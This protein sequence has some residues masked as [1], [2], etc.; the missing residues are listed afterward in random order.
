MM[1]MMKK[2]Q[3]F[4]NQ[5]PNIRQR[6]IIQ[7]VGIYVLISCLWIVFSDNIISLIFN[8]S[9]SL[10]LANIINAIIFILITGLFLFFLISKNQKEIVQVQ[11]IKAEKENILGQLIENIDEVFWAIDST[12]K[13]IYLSPSYKK[14]FG[15]FPDD[16]LTINELL[17]EHIYPDDKA[18]LIEAIQSEYSKNGENIYRI[19][20]ANGN[21]RWIKSKFLPIAHADN[22]E[23][24]ICCIARDIT[25]QILANQYLENQ[26]QERTNELERKQVIADSLSEILASL[27]SNS[28]L[29][30]ILS[31]IMCK[32]RQLLHAEA[33]AVYQLN[34]ERNF[35]EITAS[36]GLTAEYISAARIPWGKHVTGLAAASR[37]PMMISNIPSL[38]NNPSPE[39]NQTLS[40]LLILLST[41]YQSMLS[42]PLI[43]ENTSVKGTLNL[44]FKKPKTFLDGEISLANSFGTYAILA[45][46]NARLKSEAEHAVIIA[47]RNRIARDLHDSVTQTLFSAN[48]IANVLPIVWNNN[49]EEGAEALNQLNLLTKGALAEMRTL[50]LELRPQAIKDIDINT[51]LTQLASSVSIKS[52]IPI[53]VSLEGGNL[54]LAE[55]VKISI[56]RICQEALNN[57]VKHSK[58][59]QATIN[60]KCLLPP[61]PAKGKMSSNL[62]GLTSRIELC[63]ADNGKG[64]PL[65]GAQK[66]S[67]GLGIMN[68]RAEMIGADLIIESTPGKGTKIILIWQSDQEGDENVS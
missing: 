13:V 1:L 54:L 52:G 66:K 53:E 27:N 26:I 34:K 51:L 15:E 7:T 2:V 60:L 6:N 41:L 10:L 43:V 19:L 45:I 61:K 3:N 36:E 23:K 65:I 12:G 58:A 40:E 44:Y 46:E 16:N 42:V 55:E 30:E 39:L 68:E 47:E 28:E 9:A 5:I 33:V 20:T 29:D 17:L 4:Q 67:L 22:T 31:I 38:L 49:P 62:E 32:A 11:K 59:S 35:L 57:I 24:H 56:Y 21:I 37:E 63:I 8:Q 25:D 14:I 64:F 48:L 18:N 50:L